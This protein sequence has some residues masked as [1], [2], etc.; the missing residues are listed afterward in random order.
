[1]TITVLPP[2]FGAKKRPSPTYYYEQ[3]F[4]PQMTGALS[5]PEAVVRAATKNGERLGEGT[6]RVVFTIPG[7]RGFVLRL[8]PD[9]VEDAADCIAEKKHFRPVNDFL[10]GT[11]VGQAIARLRLPEAG[12]DC[13]E[14]LRQQR[15]LPFTKL[16]KKI[17]NDKTVSYYGDRE[18]YVRLYARA[19]QQVPQDNITRLARL[20]Q[21]LSKRRRAI[22]V[23]GYNVLVDWPGK[24]LNV[25]D[26]TRVSSEAEAKRHN[27]L[28][29]LIS[30]VFPVIPPSA[31]RRTQVALRSGLQKCLIAGHDTGLEQVK[32][33]YEKGVK[34]WSDLRHVVEAAGLKASWSQIYAGVCAGERV[35]LP[36]A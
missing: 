14:I 6:S 1:M 7:I 30:C 12:R 35:I 9:F 15:G 13:I 19:M 23:V 8:P 28:D 31:G 22:D 16:L 21:R 18:R 36:S 32:P 33:F 26:T 11:N 20:I 5:T 4:A 3:K 10:P 34:G 25:V 29:G 2:R 17:S 24:R 27:T